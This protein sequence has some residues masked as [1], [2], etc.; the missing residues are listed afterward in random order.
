MNSTVK[1]LCRT[2]VAAPRALRLSVNQTRRLSNTTPDAAHGREGA[3]HDPIM[4]KFWRAETVSPAAPTVKTS[5][6]AAS[7]STS[8]FTS[9]DPP[10]GT[11]VFE[12]SIAPRWSE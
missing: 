11:S 8:T 9:R 6:P 10:L 5:A 2:A 1:T 3:V 7:P 4:D 12:P